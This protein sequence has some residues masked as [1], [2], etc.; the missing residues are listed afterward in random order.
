MKQVQEALAST[1]I[2]VMRGIWRQTDEAV[3]A[4]DQYVVYSVSTKPDEEYDDHIRSMQSYV[5]MNLWSTSD[6][7][8]AIQK[9]RQAMF[10]YGFGCIEESDRGYN[11]PAYD[12]YSHRFCMAWTWVYNEDVDYVIRL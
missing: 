11:Q 12:T 3:A 9:I 2:P 4:P 6:P 1:G 8:D 5:Y 10:D 7:Y